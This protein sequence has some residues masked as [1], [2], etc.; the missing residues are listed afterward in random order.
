MDHPARDGARGAPSSSVQRRRIIGEEAEG[1][2]R[3]SPPSRQQPSSVSQA[4]ITM[5][6]I[7]ANLEEY[8]DDDECMEGDVR[9]G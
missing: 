6:D 7:D 1:G 9:I 4:D 3:R 5:S 2:D 8:N